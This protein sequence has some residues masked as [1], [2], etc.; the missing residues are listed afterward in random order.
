MAADGWR[1]TVSPERGRVGEW[2]TWTVRCTAGAAG[3]AAGGALR[4]ALPDRWHQWWRN[5]SRRVQA[6]EPAEPFYITARAVRAGAGR[7]ARVRCEVE[8]QAPFRG[9]A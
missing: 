7:E 2:G 9:A 3:L 8:Q 4:V 1:I 5:S 6:T